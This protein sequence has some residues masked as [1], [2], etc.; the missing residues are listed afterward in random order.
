MDTPLYIAILAVIAALG[1]DLVVLAVWDEW[2]RPAT[3]YWTTTY[4]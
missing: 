1:L 3:G 2:R 4:R